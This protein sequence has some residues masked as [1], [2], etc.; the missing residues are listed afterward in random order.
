M[1]MSYRTPGPWKTGQQEMRFVLWDAVFD[2][3]DSLVALVNTGEG[4]LNLIAD[5][6]ELLELLRHARKA[7]E[8]N[9]VQVPVLMAMINEVLERH[10]K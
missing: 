9:K 3:D 4:D 1:R 8:I 10:R 2:S 7:L 6:P 5:A